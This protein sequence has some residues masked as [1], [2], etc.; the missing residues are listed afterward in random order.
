MSDN[1][2]QAP[3]AE[4]VTDKSYQDFPL[5]TSG[6][7]FL[8]M[9][10]DYFGYMLLAGVIGVVLVIAEN[11][12]LIDEINDNLFGIMLIFLYYIPLESIWGRSLGKLITRTKV[13]N[14]EGD[15]ASFGQVIGR[16]C[17]RIIP[18]EAFSF[19]GGNGQPQ[20]WHDK[21]TKTKVISLKQSK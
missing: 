18:F 11:D 7:R 15:K 17:I 1:V 16:T 3:K 5:A 9:L 6:Q 4:L 20:G 12:S 21:W 10:I 14:L 19:L 2:Y 13:V 8:N